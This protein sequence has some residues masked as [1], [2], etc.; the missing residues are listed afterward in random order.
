[1]ARDKGHLTD[2]QLRHWIKA[3]QPLAKADGDGLTFT[4][5]AAGVAGWILRYRHG[6]RRRELTIGRYPDIGLAEAR[7]IAT[8]KRA[9]VQQ[10][11]NPAAEKQKAK[12]TAARDWTVRDLAKDYRA[13]KLVSLANSTQ[14]SYGRH[15]KRVEK[16]L[17]ALTVREIEASDVVALIE[18]AGLTWGESN[19]LLIT[20]KC[21]FTHACG[22]RLINA[23]PCHGIMLSALLGERPLNPNSAPAPDADA[24]GT[25]AAAGRAHAP[26]ECDDS[27]LAIRILLAT[28]VRS[29]ELYQAKW[30]DVDL[31]GTQWHIPKS[32]TGA[33][34]DIPL[35]PVVVD[36]FRELRPLAG[37]SA[38]VLPAHSRSRAARH[39]GDT[40]LNKDTLREAAVSH[41]AGW[42]PQRISC[43]ASDATQAT[44]RQDETARAGVS[45]H[46]PARRATAGC[47]GQLQH[48]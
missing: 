7:G 38:Y 39:G 34:M 11:R 43:I 32:K 42:L 37:S 17:G 27:A 8:L 31:D 10:G 18:G 14:V 1:M 25:E 6:G 28:A 44:H 29:A 19:M 4:L 48:P 20:T 2:L 13:K 26:P 35:A 9:E 40:H 33:A 30:A 12:A 23:N 47:T 45:G 41:R 21:L 3:G 16:K 22:K 36:W 5:S 24:R 46:H 15:L